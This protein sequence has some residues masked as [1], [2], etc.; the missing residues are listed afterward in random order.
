[1]VVLSERNIQL[2]TQAHAF[3]E[4]KFKDEK[5]IQKL[6]E[7]A[8]RDIQALKEQTSVEYHQL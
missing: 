1:M 7:E 4:Q 5:L 8:F 6:K 3:K 2:E